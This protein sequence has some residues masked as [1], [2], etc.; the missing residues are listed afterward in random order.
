MTSNPRDRILGR[1]RSALGREAK[2]AWA[3]VSASRQATLGDAP[4]QRPIW[5]DEDLD[6]FTRCFEAAAGTWTRVSSIEKI[7]AA[8]ADYL[9]DKPAGDTVHLSPHPAFDQVDWPDTL[10][11][12]QATHGRDALVGVSVASLGVAETGS[13]ALLSGADSPTTLSFLPDYHIVVLSTSR[14]VAHFEEVWEY[15]RDHDRF[16]PRSFNF[17]TGPS[18]TAD[19]EQTLQLGAHGPRSL[20]LVLVDETV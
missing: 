4:P 15:M 16:P 11:L 9:A 7:G 13:L 10:T 14:V 19:V 3:E 1:I 8:V 17:I 18:R 2:P 20:H 5:R 12:R 6:R